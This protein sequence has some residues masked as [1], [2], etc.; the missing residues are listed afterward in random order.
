LQ[1]FFLKLLPVFLISLQP[2]IKVT[3]VSLQLL[4]ESFMGADRL[5]ELLETLLKETFVLC[6]SHAWMERIV[7]M[8]CS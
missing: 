2:L 6:R 7:I 5:I 8:F 3:L 1:P 4:T